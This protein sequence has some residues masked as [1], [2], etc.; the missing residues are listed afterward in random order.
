MKPQLTPEQIAA[1]AQRQADM[2]A[3]RRAEILA[4]IAWWTKTEKWR[5][6]GFNIVQTD[7]MYA[8][9]TERHNKR[10]LEELL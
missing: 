9:F 7:P 3:A 6:E 10:K 4:T 2:L 1:N 5:N 8:K